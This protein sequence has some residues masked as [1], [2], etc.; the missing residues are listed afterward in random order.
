MP[1]TVFAMQATGHANLGTWGCQVGTKKR[2]GKKWTGIL[3]EYVDARYI[4]IHII[5][6]IYNKHIYMLYKYTSIFHWYLCIHIWSY[7]YRMLYLDHVPVLPAGSHH[8]WS[9]RWVPFPTWDPMEVPWRF[10]MEVPKSWMVLD[11][12]FNGNPMKIDVFFGY[13]LILGDLH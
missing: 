7:G 6:H 4:Y 3:L 13:T 9:P 8:C 10:P 2:S 12:F 5:K 1:W 11:V